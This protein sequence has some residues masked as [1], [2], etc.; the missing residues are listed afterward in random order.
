M[1]R[2]LLW[3]AVLINLGIGVACLVDP[4]GMLVP[5]GVGPIESPEGVIEL[6]AMYGGLEIGLGLF[7]AWCA[8][9]PKRAR[10]GLI[11]AT[12]PIAGLGLV[13]LGSCLVVGFPEGWLFPFLCVVEVGG[14]AFSAAVLWWTR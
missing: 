12:L 4:L 13:R 10:L 9:S 1:V 11:A 5:V 2:V 7:L 6:R 8:I 14:A 3:M